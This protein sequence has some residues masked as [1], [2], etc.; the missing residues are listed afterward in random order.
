MPERYKKFDKIIIVRYSMKRIN[1]GF[2]AS[3]G[4]SN[5]QAVLDAI[6]TGHLLAKPCVL[7]SNNSTSRAIERAQIQGMPYYHFSSSTHPDPEDL[8]S[9]ILNALIN[10]EVEYILLVGYMRKLGTN[11]LKEYKGRILN[12]HPSLLPK[13]GGKGMYGRFVHEEVLKNKE[14]ETGVSIH[15]VDEEYDTGRIIDQTTIPVFPD[16]T[17][18]TLSNRVLKKEHEF[19]VETL[20]KVSNGEII[21]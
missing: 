16:D 12:I 7:I 15:L 13:Y 20:I 1:I 2:M 21:L 19:L 11:I 6:N 18:E 4:G 14:E 17:F 8:D 5:M 3:H 9:C 10:H